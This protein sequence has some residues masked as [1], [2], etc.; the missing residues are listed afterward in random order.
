M[1]ANS[2]R[3]FE[4]NSTHL[5]RTAAAALALAIVFAFTMIATPAAQ[6]QTFKVIHTFT[7]GADGGFPF[8]GL[9]IDA[10][11]NLYGTTNAG[12]G[13][14]YGTAFKLKPSGSG[15]ILAPIYTFVAG[16][17]H[18]LPFGRLAF[19][20]DRTL[21]G[22]S[23]DAGS[24]CRE[25]DGC[26]M[27]FHL[28][29]SPAAPKSALAPWKETVTYAFNGNDGLQPSGDL[30]F[31]QSG[32]IYGTTRGGGNSNY[33]VIY[34]LTLGGSGWTESILY[35]P[36]TRGEGA[37]PEGGVVF[38]GSGN[39]YGV[40][41]YGGPYGYGAV[42]E[43]S[44]SGSSWTEQTVYGFTGGSDGG[45]PMHGLIMD[46]S[47]NLYGTTAQGGGG[48]GGTVFELTRTSGGWTFSTL[49][50][51]SPGCC[52]GPSDKLVMDAA[53]SLYGTTT[54]DGAYGYG[55]VFKV[56]PSE[57]GWTYSSLHDFT[58]QSGSDGAYP[59]GGLV[60]DAKG[61]LYGTASEGGTYN[62][63]TVFEITP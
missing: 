43:L 41:G 46:S 53:G 47:D 11:G 8:A 21:F 48:G 7:G 27:V 13:N 31:D 39:L 44:P 38:D 19:G 40:F 37:G 51:F 4:K 26:G 12:G 32:N 45:Q 33:G 23:P 63:G 50:G 2:L 15:W 18:G 16:D 54:S 1:N 3:G 55:N 56:T 35:A 10:A 62:N 9:T 58:G 22:T 25:Y 14:G 20:R 29:P 30:I 49:Y 5:A 17:H 34:N 57:G 28:Q 59:Q 24:G 60:F 61:N 6:A 52:G 42:Y 36:Q